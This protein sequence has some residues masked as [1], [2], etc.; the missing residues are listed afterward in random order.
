MWAL[1][2]PG[3]TV[4]L[5]GS[6][7]QPVC[8]TSPHPRP[9]WVHERHGDTPA[10]R[11]R[12]GGF[13]GRRLWVLTGLTLRAV[14]PR[15]P[16]PQSRA[17]GQLV[18]APY[19]QALSAHLRVAFKGMVI[20]GSRWAQDHRGQCRAARDTVGGRNARNTATGETDTS[21]QEWGRSGEE[22][23]RREVWASLSIQAL[24]SLL[25]GVSFSNPD[26][27]E[28]GQGCGTE[29]APLPHAQQ[30]YGP[31]LHATSRKTR[32]VCAFDLAMSPDNRIHAGDCELIIRVKGEN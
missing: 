23:R 26:K 7:L 10:S 30:Q 4:T 8:G 17:W 12:G 21:L 14:R 22:I 5:R 32:S 13:T 15:D 19:S 2:P 24:T 20:L 31:T 16:Q 28:D 18:Q 6:S 29:A 3:P 27:L 11:G 9:G 25:A 1:S